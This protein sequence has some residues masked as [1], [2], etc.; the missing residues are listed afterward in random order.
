MFNF[1]VSK[2]FAFWEFFKTNQGLLFE[3]E[4]L[5]NFAVCLRNL[6]KHNEDAKVDLLPVVANL[7]R[8]VR[9]LQ[10]LRTK[11]NQPICITSGFRSRELNSKVRGVPDS[12]HLLGLAA[13]ITFDGCG[14]YTNPPK[15]RFVPYVIESHFEDLIKLKKEGILSEL[16]F[17]DNYI[18]VAI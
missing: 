9:V 18:H 15:N 8:L 1:M 13:D 3:C 7:L 4:Q 10:D 17:H 16:I 12:K 5:A 14:F 6:I 11:W 2:N